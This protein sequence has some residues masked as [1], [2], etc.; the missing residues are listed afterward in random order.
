MICNM[1]KIQL[2]E[3]EYQAELHTYFL[4]NSPEMHPK[5]KR[6]IVVICPGGGYEMTSDREAEPIAVRFLAMGFHAAVLRYSV[7]PAHYPEALLQLAKSIC[8]IR[9][10]AEQYHIDAN[11]IIIQGSSAGGHLAASLGVFWNQPDIARMIGVSP[12]MFR[13]NGLILCY[14]VITTGEKA[15][16]G[17][18]RKLLGENVK[19]IIK[20]KEMSLELHVTKDTPKTFLWHTITDDTVP[21]EN[22]L[23]FFEALHRNHVLAELHIYPV[24]GHGLSLANE[25]TSN[26]NGYGVQPECQSWIEL[27]GIWMKHL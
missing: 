10:H 15:H 21:V 7:A 16:Q 12:E 19:D 4:D 9:E 25:E 17:S 6:P 18:F 26:E 8:Y 27:A 11:K 14:P 2:P 13:P 23:L 1:I 3:S 24:G 22:S 20:R 5:K